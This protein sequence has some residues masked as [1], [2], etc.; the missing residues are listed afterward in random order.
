[1]TFTDAAGADEDDVF[2]ALDKAEVEKTLQL[3][4]W[5]AGGEV[6]IVVFK[7]FDG[8]Q[9]GEFQQGRLS[10]AGSG[11]DFD[12]QQ[13]FQKIRQALVFGHSVIGNGRPFGGDGAELQILAGESN[14][15]VLEV[16][17]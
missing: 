12:F 8:R 1:M 7:S 10:P 15:L 9:A 5:G 4:F 16:H 2:L 14:A 3:L 13:S 11:G 6:E 17:A